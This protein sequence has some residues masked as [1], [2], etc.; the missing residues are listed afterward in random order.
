M[1]TTTAPS[2][3][4]RP[5]TTSAV[6]RRFADAPTWSRRSERSLDH[7]EVPSTHEIET[8]VM[9]N[10]RPLAMLMIARP[11]LGTVAFWIA[12]LQGWW[13]IAVPLVWLVYG[14]GVSGVHHLIHGSM[15][16]SNKARHFWLSAL[17]C[18]VVESG[19][20]LQTTHLL[21]HRADGDLPDPEG[22]VE[23]A[24]WA[25]MPVAATLFRYR[26][27]FWG[28]RY[29]RRRKLIAGE[30]AFHAVAHLASLAL[31][32]VLPELWIHVTL[33]HVASFTFAV[34]AGK[35][36][37]TNWGR[38]IESPLVRVHTRLGRIVFFSHDQHLEHH[39]WPKVP[40]CRLPKLH[41]HLEPALAN[42]KVVDV[43]LAL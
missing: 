14:S 4:T 6:A 13:L 2:T 28:L 17:G 20:A 8:D 22:C 23:N 10:L 35:G 27:A 31:L 25:E 15:G 12:A 39:A 32:P 43:K 30:M 9:E 18:L 16:L 24:T 38:A 36:P 26:L 42:R 33:L 5:Y 19:H 29:G 34:F 41:E 40:L 1:T 7:I 21:H 3:S 37:Q 11:V